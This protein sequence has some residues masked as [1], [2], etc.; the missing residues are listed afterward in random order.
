MC[1]DQR[2]QSGKEESKNSGFNILLVL[3]FKFNEKTQHQLDSSNQPLSTA[4]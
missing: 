3:L 1:I 2:L 4:H